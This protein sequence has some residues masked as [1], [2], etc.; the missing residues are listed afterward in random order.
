M[1]GIK[2]LVEAEVL[3]KAARAMSPLLPVVIEG[4]NRNGKR[5]MGLKVLCAW[6][7]HAK[8]KD[9]QAQW[10][11][12]TTSPPKP[13]SK[14]QYLE[15]ELEEEIDARLARILG[16]QKQ[17]KKH[18]RLRKKSTDFPGYLGSQSTFEKAKKHKK[19]ATV[20]SS[21]S[22]S[23]DSSSELSEE[24]RSRKRSKAPTRKGQEKD[25]KV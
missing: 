18:D 4:I 1:S 22:S 16:A 14:K 5:R 25:M 15:K 9:V 8:V 10:K 2:H 24:E 12:T 23:S 6:F 19:R 17:G 11:A 3:K 21:S 20:S 7:L 13:D